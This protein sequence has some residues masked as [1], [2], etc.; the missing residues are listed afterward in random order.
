MTQKLLELSSLTK[1]FGGVTAVQD[2]S[3]SME[4][5]EIVALIGP[6]GAGKTTAFN[7]VSGIFPCTSGEVW[8]DGQKIT[9]K[10]SYEIAQMGITRTFQNLQIFQTMNVVENVM[11]GYHTLLKSGIFRSGLRFKSVNHEEKEA[12]EKALSLLERLNLR[13]LANQNAATLP[14]G[15][16]R[17]VEIARAAAAEPKLILLD[18]PMAGLNPE[19]SRKV[20]DAILK[21]REEGL[22][23]L[24]VE[25]DMETV[26]SLADK[27][28][29]LDYGKKIA[30]GTPD[31]V[32]QNKEVIEAYLGEEEDVTCYY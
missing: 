5:S 30:E 9:N 14:Y 13:D 3:F 2:V 21:M 26:M 32:S 7:M 10:K 6:N 22:A 8:F 20:T 31:E 18:E 17:L 27:I 4:P 16:Q 19:E 15:T 24:F 25:H 1:S 23:F 11:T 12:L 28:V 29:V